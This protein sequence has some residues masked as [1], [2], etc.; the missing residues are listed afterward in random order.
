[1]SVW[2]ASFLAASVLFA[3]TMQVT[4]GF[5]FALLAV[6]LMSLAIDTHDAVVVS[7]FLGLLTSSLQAVRERRHIQR[8]LVLSLSGSAVI[9]IPIGLL[10]FRRVDENTLKIVLGVGVL[11]A[12]VLLARRLDLSTKGR[13]VEWTAGVLSGALS[14][15][16]STNGP[17]LVFALQS[18]RLPIDAFRATISAVFCLSGV[19]T[20][21]AFAVTDEIRADA[22][23]ETLIA[24]PAMV[25][26]AVVGY[27]TR[28]LFTEE[29]ARRVVLALLGLAGVSTL[30]SALAG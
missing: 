30:V 12:A 19:L 9:G 8:D 13:S 1:M 14:S 29:V 23:R 15:S 6:P 10:L 7:T 16:L 27:R 18:R 11:I 25:V 20:I 3:S 21:V 17:P 5:G 4:A 24:L 26:G 28:R 22:V 2:A